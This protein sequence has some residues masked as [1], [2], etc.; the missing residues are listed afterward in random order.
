MSPSPGKG[1]D[2]ITRFDPTPIP[3]PRIPS[4]SPSKVKP[5]YDGKVLASGMI[6]GGEKKARSV[7]Q[8][9]FGILLGSSIDRGE[10]GNLSFFILNCAREL[11]RGREFLDGLFRIL[12]AVGVLFFQ[13]FFHFSRILPHPRFLPTNLTGNKM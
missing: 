1:L 11:D 12:F 5:F 9:T 4:S 2:D 6:S 3:F 13:K 8:M 10:S 7:G